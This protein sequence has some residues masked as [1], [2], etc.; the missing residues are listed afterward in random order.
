MQTALRRILYIDALAGAGKTYAIVRHAHKLVTRGGKVIIAQPTKQLIDRTVAD[1][2]SQLSGIRYRVIHGDSTSSVIAEIVR[3][4]NECGNEPELLF[5]TQASFFALP[6]FW[7]R[8][9]RSTAT[10][11][12]ISPTI[13]DCCFPISGL[14]MRM[15]ATLW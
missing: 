2:L 9:R 6:S 10:T 12:S 14:R 1:E 5:I 3:H 4:L 13:T 8:S 7:M 15:A 11:S